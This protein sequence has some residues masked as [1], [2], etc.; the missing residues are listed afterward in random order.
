MIYLYKNLEH[1]YSSAEVLA[2][3]LITPPPKRETK[4]KEEL[5]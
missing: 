1:R 5:I 2:H 4:R 3:D